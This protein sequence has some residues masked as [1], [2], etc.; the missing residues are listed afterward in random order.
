M[1]PR[2]THRRHY[3]RNP[4]MLSAIGFN[5][6]TLKAVG[7]TVVGLAG[8]PFIE[9]FITPYIPAAIGQNAFGKYAV[10]VAAALG[11][12][13]GVKKVAGPEAGRAVM[14]GGI[15][16]VAVSLIRDFLPT[17]L[18]A[19]SSTGL[20]SMGAQPLLGAKSGLSSPMTTAIP[21]RWNPSGRF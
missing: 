3:R 1:N 9:G 16:Y 17:L 18:P 20:Y 6:P 12:S 4:D 7:F 15:A 14:V 8:T 21:D 19:S 5:Q 11:L 13:W 2:R 10:K